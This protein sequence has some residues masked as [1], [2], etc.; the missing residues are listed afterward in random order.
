MVK[1]ILKNMN[2]MGRNILPSF[3]TYYIATVIKTV[4]YYWQ[5]DEHTES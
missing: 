1:M 4:C 5:S 3:K 2:K